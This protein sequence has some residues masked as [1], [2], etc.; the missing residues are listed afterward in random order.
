MI[1]CFVC[2][3][4]SLWKNLTKLWHAS[5]GELL[6][7][8]V[9]PGL[10]QV[11]LYSARFSPQEVTAAGPGQT[12]SL[13]SVCTCTSASPLSFQ[14]ELHRREVS[15]VETWS[16]FHWQ[17]KLHHYGEVPALSLAESFRRLQMERQLLKEVIQM[18]AYLTRPDIVGKDQRKHIINQPIS[19][20]ISFSRGKSKMK[21]YVHEKLRY[22]FMCSFI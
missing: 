10:E 8:P 7:L 17:C 19:Y 5:S 3:P 16:R 2:F 18:S 22:K 15:D 21:I 9:L 6:A 1:F 12:A 4:R 14:T 13:C 11:S 20:S